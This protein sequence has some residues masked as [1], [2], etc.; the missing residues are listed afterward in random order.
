MA[1]EAAG[2]SG[3]RTQA[4]EFADTITTAAG[5][6]PLPPRKAVMNSRQAGAGREA[7]RHAGSNQRVEEAR[8][9]HQAIRLYALCS[10]R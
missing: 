4:D 8:D 3:R 5:R 1:L 6:P 9:R 2:Y 7:A 10:V